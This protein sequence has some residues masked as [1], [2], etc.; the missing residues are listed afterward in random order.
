MSARV[1]AA[2]HDGQDLIDYCLKVAFGRGRQAAKLRLEAVDMLWDRGFGRPTQYQEVSGPDGGPLE[3]IVRD[4]SGFTPSQLHE[5]VALR[6]R[7]RE[8]VE[9]E[10]PS[11]ESPVAEE[12]SDAATG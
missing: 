4:M 5:L 2:T 7:L 6:A 1:R 9:T 3:T 8:I 12:P 10:P 11:R